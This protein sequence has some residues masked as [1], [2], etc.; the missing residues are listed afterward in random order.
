MR[1]NRR[2]RKPI[3]LFSWTLLLW[4]CIITFAHQ[5][6][7]TSALEEP[8]QPDQTCSDANDEACREQQQQDEEAGS[9]TASLQSWFQDV[10][11]LVQTE[12]LQFNRFLQDT[13]N[14]VL[15][16]PQ[17]QQAQDQDQEHEEGQFSRLWKTKSERQQQQHA[18]DREAQTHGREDGNF[19]HGLSALLT[20]DSPG[21]A[22]LNLV[23]HSDNA[24]RNQQT[25]LDTIARSQAHASE[26]QQQFQRA[27]PDWEVYPFTPMAAYYFLQIQEEVKNAVWK[28][29]QHKFLPRM[30]DVEALKEYH[31]ALYLSELAY[32]QTLEDVQRG[33]E[34]FENGSW[35][36]LYATVESG[37]HQP[38]HFFAVPRGEDYTPRTSIKQ[39]RKR[40]RRSP[41]RQRGAG[42]GIG[43]ASILPWVK[44]SSSSST[45][46]E[47]ERNNNNAKIASILPWDTTLVESS[48][49]P[50]QQSDDDDDDND[51]LEVAL[52][53][54]GT[55][56]PGDVVS[57][58]LFET[59][60]YR[61]GHR[62]HGG[63]LEAGRFLVQTHIDRLE[64]L[65]KLSGKR[66]LRLWCIGHSLGGGA[67]SIAAIEFNDYGFIEA[68]AIGFGSPSL[69][70]A[71]LSESYQDVITTI[72]SDSD[73]VPRLSAPS[74]VRLYY[75]M[76]T[77][78]HGELAK[79]D[80][81]DLM[82]HLRTKAQ[83]STGVKVIDFLQAQLDKVGT[84]M[85]ERIQEYVL[86][87]KDRFERYLQRQ[88][89]TIDRG[90][91]NEDYLEPAGTC[92]H[93][94]RDGTGYTGAYTPC[95]FFTEID[96]VPSMID[97]HLIPPG[98]HRAL[99]TLARDLLQDLDFSFEHQQ[100][101][102]TS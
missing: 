27:F 10:R 97:D 37:P 54:R 44:E 22:F 46:R 55:K 16:G 41:G 4:L 100:L 92:I 76:M 51:Y 30:T 58:V 35:A 20:A 73:V 42:S 61:N 87:H 102:P 17:Q 6:L 96:F 49:P 19:L 60:D 93:L 18:A 77:H 90:G 43:I 83:R 28:R 38:A 81:H 25:W 47:A 74:M 52:V 33:L 99:V 29:R 12:G 75:R 32:S 40:K 3:L 88:Q 45:S 71:Q 7:G 34:K 59:V 53:V 50:Q 67:A 9:N 63:V 65:L 89:D 48:F 15:M 72:I 23:T 11:D 66:V 86:K 64:H 79:A 68:S 1:P 101:P 2:E 57:D 31:N 36:L 85:D 24:D 78:H 56:E 14:D 80:L 95:S 39:K 82:R 94:Y 26:F 91:V 21:E 70:S 69:L 84:L 13:V 8:Q 62:A 5:I 98:Y